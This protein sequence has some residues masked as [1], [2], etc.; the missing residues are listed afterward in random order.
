MTEKLQSESTEL[1][2]VDKH[3]RVKRFVQALQL[4]EL[5]PFA[6]S[7]EEVD[8]FAVHRLEDEVLARDF[9]I[10]ADAAVI[11]QDPL[12]ARKA[13]GAVGLAV[14]V[15]LLWASIAQVD[16]ITKGEGKV[17]PSRQ[18][19][20]VQS[21]DGGIVSDILVKEGE[22]VRE[23]Q[24]LV[25]IDATRFMSSFKES[26][27]TYLS[28]LAKAARLRAVAEGVDFVPPPEVVK[29]DPKLVEQ[30]RLLYMNRKAE[31]DAQVGIAR[32]Q[33]SQRTHELG[34]ARA[35]YESAQQGYELTSRELTLTR[36]LIQSGAVSDVELLRLQR[37]V[38][39]YAGERGQASSQ[40]TRLQ[41]AINES[42]RKIQEVEL[43]FKNQ[44]R[45]ELSETQ[46]K[47]NSL[48]E[49]SVALSDKVKQ[50]DIRSP[51]NGTIKRILY[52]T[53]GGVVQPGKDIVEVVPLED[54]LLLEAR[55]QPRDIAFLRPGQKANVKLTAYDFTIYGGLDATLEHIS[56]DSVLDE[57]GN[58]F[59]VVRVRTQRPNFGENLPII[60]GMTAEVDIMTG[61]KSVL[62]YLLKPVLRAK[63]YAL[64][65][66]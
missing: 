51:V 30:E 64:T 57:K 58:A 66:R 29:E 47:I 48:G 55:V 39:R 6:R 28:L 24:V 43:E 27:A 54:A 2:P 8:P 50:A 62:S 19:Q 5:N 35:R 60:P 65:E 59:Y 49:G 3:Q 32:E 22:Q 38:S 31:L 12:R 15:F 37:D 13:I 4:N 11:S 61:K 53:V 56:A 9:V 36:P 21:L 25:K 34:E 10:D 16:Q 14:V 63:Q 52:N 23:G 45:N 40:I 18:L 7:T 33:L 17:I 46:A 26:R 20:V 44:A 1:A 42:Q 41:A